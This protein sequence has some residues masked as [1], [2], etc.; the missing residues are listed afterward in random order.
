MLY[1]KDYITNLNF[2]AAET[3]RIQGGINIGNALLV[4][5]SVLDCRNG[6]MKETDLTVTFGFEISPFGTE[7]EELMGIAALAKEEAFLSRCGVYYR[8]AIVFLDARRQVIDVL[9]LCFQCLEM[10]TLK[11]EEH[12]FS[13][14]ASIE[15]IGKILYA[16]INY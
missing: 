13:D 2:S 4:G 6:A 14:S 1:L 12:V 11:G 16:T 8:D 7:K 15:S 10:R 3:Y 9:L 5:E